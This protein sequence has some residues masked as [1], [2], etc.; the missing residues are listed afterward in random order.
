MFRFHAGQ[1]LATRQTVV[2]VK[3]ALHSPVS[4][5]Q[6]RHPYLRLNSLPG[7]SLQLRLE[8]FAEGRKNRVCFA[9]ESF[10]MHLNDGFK[11]CDPGAWQCVAE[12]QVN[13]AMAADM[14]SKH[15]A[16]GYREAGS[17]RGMQ[18]FLC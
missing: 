4:S 14:L 18:K 9:F 16:P 2:Q 6:A 10:D 17:C 3:L 13:Q 12:T 15:L 11:L 5:F 7:T 1:L 8:Q